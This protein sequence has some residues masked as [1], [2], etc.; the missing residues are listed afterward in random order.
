MVLMPVTINKFNLMKGEIALLKNKGIS[1]QTFANRI[2]QCHW[3]KEKAL[4]KQVCKREML[5]IE[6]KAMLKRNK[7]KISTY[8]KRR[9][10]G[11]TKQDAMSVKPRTYKMEG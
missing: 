11:W 8:S 6:E 7:I 5:T 2:T 9:A 10:R 1:R 3:S 4:S